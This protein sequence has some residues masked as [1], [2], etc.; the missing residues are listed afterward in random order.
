[1][2][3]LAL[4]STQGCSYLRTVT[5]RVRLTREEHAIKVRGTSSQ[6]STV[7]G[8]TLYSSATG[9][10]R[11]DLHVCIAGIIQQ[12][13]NVCKVAI[14]VAHHHVLRLGRQTGPSG[15]ADHSMHDWV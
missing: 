5:S 3:I 13:S 10:T 11:H 15:S 6:Y 14:G 12:P 4:L 1:M 2:Q 9:A 7:T 8:K